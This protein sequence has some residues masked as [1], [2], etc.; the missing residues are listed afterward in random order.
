VP[1]L[2]LKTLSETEVSPGAYLRDVRRRLGLSL[3]DVQDASN[4]LAKDE[5]NDE[6][7]ISA[8]RL[9]QIENEP[10]A[11]S[12]HKLLSLSAIYGLDVHSSIPI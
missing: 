12:I 3:L 7:Y 4:L 11:P 6:M 8:A 5:N 2:R 1:N 9:H 10:S